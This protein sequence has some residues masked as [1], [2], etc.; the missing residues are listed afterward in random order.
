MCEEKIGHSHFTDLVT[1]IKTAM[2]NTMTYASL[3]APIHASWGIDMYKVREDMVSLNI[4]HTT[5]NTVE[6][7]A[8]NGRRAIR[9][10]RNFIDSINSEQVPYS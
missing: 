6:Q 3:A 5:N 10:Y 9:S 2:S 7:T 8:D 1:S 4:S